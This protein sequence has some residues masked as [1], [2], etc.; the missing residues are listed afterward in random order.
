M[1]NL[2][3]TRDIELNTLLTAMQKH[4]AIFEKTNCEAKYEAWKQVAKE[5]HMEGEYKS[6]VNSDFLYESPFLLF[7]FQLP[8]V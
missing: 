5:L 8:T 1:E 3:V 7:A 6:Y 2:I 4:P